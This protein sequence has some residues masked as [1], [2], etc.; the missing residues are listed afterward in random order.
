MRRFFL[1]F[2]NSVQGESDFT[3]SCA[4]FAISFDSRVIRHPD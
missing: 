1:T 4:L 3:S 2:L